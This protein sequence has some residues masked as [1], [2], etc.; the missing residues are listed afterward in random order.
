VTMS[1]FTAGWEEQL[2]QQA[3]LDSPSEASARPSIKG[4]PALARAFAECARITRAHSN[5]FFLTSGLLPG[6]AGQA[7]RALYAF[8]RISDDLADTVAEDAHVRLDNWRRQSLAESP[9]ATAPVPLAWAATRARYGIPLRYAEQLLDAL[10]QDLAKTRYRN[11]GEVV[12]Y[13][14]GVASTVGLMTMHIIGFEGSQAVRYAIRLGVALQLTNILRDVGEDWR[15]GR[16]Y[17]PQDELA[18]FGVTEVDIAAGI[19]HQP[20]REFMR[21]QIDRARRLYAAAL[22]GIALLHPRGRLAIAASAELYAAILDDIEQHD[23]DVFRRRA[24]VSGWSKLL[25]L[26]SIWWKVWADRYA[27]PSHGAAGP[28]AP[29][30]RVGREQAGHVETTI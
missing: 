30:P 22:P 10:A 9:P 3:I 13:C 2:L 25:R 21:F 19:V 4:S 24:H 26:P 12:Q 8:C 7:A 15:N 14:Y 11:F 20:W 17:L 23:F 6:E 27:R 1:R 18:A 28:Q 29:L 16:V 5:T